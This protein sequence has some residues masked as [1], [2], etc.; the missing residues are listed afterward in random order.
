M[1][2]LVVGDTVMY[3]GGMFSQH[4]G[5]LGTITTINEIYGDKFISMELLTPKKSYLT[6]TARTTLTGITAPYRLFKPFTQG[7]EV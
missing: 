3:E 7:W 6:P 4:K 2:T 5:E 1:G